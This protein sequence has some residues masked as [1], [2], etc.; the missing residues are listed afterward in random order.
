MKT[1]ST[2]G[3][4]P[5]HLP[6]QEEKQN[7][8]YAY[9]TQSIF[10]AQK[11]ITSNKELKKNIRGWKWCLTW[12]WVVV[13]WDKNCEIGEVWHWCSPPSF[14]FNFF[15]IF[16]CFCLLPS[17]RL[18]SSSCFNI[19]LNRASLFNVFPFLNVFAF[20]AYLQKEKLL[21]SKEIFY[22]QVLQPGSSQK[23]SLRYRLRG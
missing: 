2:W 9:Y 17:Y 1:L 22:N 4:F 23:Q 20:K 5:L 7:L 3:I 12:L 18:V 8:E 19:A 11:E 6:C 10:Q 15:S 14:L 21:N 13:D 16:C